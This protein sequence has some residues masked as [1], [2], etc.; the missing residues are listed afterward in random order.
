MSIFPPLLNKPSPSPSL[1]P[2][3]NQINERC[4]NPELLSPSDRCNTK[5]LATK[6]I[7]DRVQE[8]L[9]TSEWQHAIFPLHSG[10]LIC[11]GWWLSN[12][13]F[14]CFKSSIFKSRKTSQLSKG[15]IMSHFPPQ[16]HSTKFEEITLSGLPKKFDQNWL[17]DE[18]K[19]IS[20]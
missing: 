3:H 18:K 13:A 4:A 6:I 10:K 1:T 7:T 15:V 20:R 11:S 8:L 12:T 9:A 19:I 14:T 5:Q 2:L 16:L 17:L